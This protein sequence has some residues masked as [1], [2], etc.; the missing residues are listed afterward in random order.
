LAVTGMTNHP[1][2]ML[3]ELRHKEIELRK[4]FDGER[5]KAKGR[6]AVRPFAV[7]SERQWL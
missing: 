7:R 1:E 4:R 2:R 3:D 5:A 6:T